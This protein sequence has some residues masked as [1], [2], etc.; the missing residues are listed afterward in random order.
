MIKAFVCIVGKFCRHGNTRTLAKTKPCIRQIGTKGEFR[1]Y[2]A[3]KLFLLRLVKI[4]RHLVRVNVFIRIQN[5]QR[6]L[7]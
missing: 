1:E 3:G 7:H 2:I 6:L 4:T 5:C